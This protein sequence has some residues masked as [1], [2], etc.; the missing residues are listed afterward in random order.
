MCFFENTS[1][2]S[3][4]FFLS[5]NYQL[6]NTHPQQTRQCKYIDAQ[7]LVD[8]YFLFKFTIFNYLPIRQE[9]LTQDLRLNPIL[10]RAENLEVKPRSNPRQFSH[11]LEGCTVQNQNF[12][13]VFFNSPELQDVLWSQQENQEGFLTGKVG[14]E[15]HPVLKGGD[16]VHLRRSMHGGGSIAGYPLPNTSGC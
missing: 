3:V 14:V 11:D 7:R 9:I 8:I 13:E 10:T 16:F 15:H 2:T 4:P 1:T 5:I 12:Q 6:I